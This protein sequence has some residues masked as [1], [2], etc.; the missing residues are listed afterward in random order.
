[1][2]NKKSTIAL[3]II[4]VALFIV[5][6]F[7]V[8]YAYF[9]STVNSE[10]DEGSSFKTAELGATFT[11]GPEVVIDNIIPGDSFEKTFSIT[12]N[13]NNEMRYNV[14]LQEVVNEFLAPADLT[15]VLKEDGV[16]IA[17]GT[18][19]TITK[20]LNTNVLSIAGK[21]SDGTKTTKNY[22]LIVTY[23]NTDVEQYDDM[24]KT[25][26]GKLF[27]EEV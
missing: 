5:A 14:V 23:L 15:Y 4:G 21:S 9:T 18:F 19:P 24:G 11:D 17:T 25:I 8:S 22:S 26:S 12:N 13:G 10:V 7:A 20:A 27:I 2:V 3:S 1:M 16:E 6:V